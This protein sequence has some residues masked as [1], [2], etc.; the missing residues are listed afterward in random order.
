MRDLQ[1]LS[2]KQLGRFGRELLECKLSKTYSQFVVKLKH[3]GHLCAKQS[4][5]K[6]INKS[7]AHCARGPALHKRLR[8]ETHILPQRA[9]TICHNIVACKRRNRQ[10]TT[11]TKHFAS[12]SSAS[13]D[14][15]CEQSRASLQKHHTCTFKR[16]LKKCHNVSS[17][18][19]CSRQV[20]RPLLLKHNTIVLLLIIE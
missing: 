3:R 15:S 1:R 6:T 14:V 13:D 2:V 18:T 4:S 11:T 5:L 9:S 17:S 10:S 20:T 19:R 16:E 7:S 12:S 8:T